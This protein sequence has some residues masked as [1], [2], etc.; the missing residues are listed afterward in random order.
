MITRRPLTPFKPDVKVPSEFKQRIMQIQQYD[1]ELSR[2]VLKAEDL[3]E[4]IFNSY[5]SNVHWSTKLEGNPLTEDEVKRITRDTMTETTRTEAP[6][7]PTQEIINH[8][9]VLSGSANYRLP[10]DENKIQ[11]LHRQLLSNTNYSG[12]TGSYRVSEGVIQENDGTAVFYATPPDAIK[13]QM[14][15]LIDWINNYS[16][17]YHPVVSATIMFHEFESI[18]PFSDGNGRT[19][20]SLFHLYLQQNGLP[21]SYLCKVDE[22]VL[23]DKESYYQL[24]AYTDYSKSYSELIDYMSDC[25]LNSYSDAVEYL[26]TKDLMSSGLNELSKRLI[27]KGKNTNGWFKASDAY[28][29]I[30]GRGEQTVRAH[31]NELCEDDIFEKRGYTKSLEYKFKDPLE[32]YFAKHKIDS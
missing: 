11:A 15:Y 26:K 12:L 30:D 9:G 8:L 31:L 19:G 7:G 13:G 18:H 4:I 32:S 17:A 14:D 21:N 2:F 24:L 6:N 3:S 1:F 28:S 5:S 27:I 23:K 20:R 29:W 16:T 22:N 25:I 10:W